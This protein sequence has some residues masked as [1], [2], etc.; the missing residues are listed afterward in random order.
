MNHGDNSVAYDV[1]SGVGVGTIN[2]AFLAG[3]AK[4]SEEEAA[5]SMVSIWRGM[6]QE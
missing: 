3:H 4:G 2:G 5:K 1:I 6:T